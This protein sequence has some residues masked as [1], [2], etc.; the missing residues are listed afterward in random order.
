MVRFFK[1]ACEKVEAGFSRK[2]C[3]NQGNW[4]KAVKPLTQHG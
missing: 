3:G 2:R 4:R 1:A